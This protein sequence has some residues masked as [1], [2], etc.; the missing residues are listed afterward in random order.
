MREPNI[1]RPLRAPMNDKMA[2]NDAN[3]SNSV[4]L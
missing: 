3:V 1:H 4:S 2:D